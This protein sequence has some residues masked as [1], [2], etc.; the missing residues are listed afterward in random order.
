[1]SQTESKPNDSAQNDLIEAGSV[2]VLKA[3]RAG[4]RIAEVVPETEI[5]LPTH[6]ATPARK[7]SSAP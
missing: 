5:D 6:E 7:S 1:M 3:D 2:E 4:L